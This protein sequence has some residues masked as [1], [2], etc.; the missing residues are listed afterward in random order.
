MSGEKTE[1]AAAA[2]PE[3]KVATKAVGMRTIADQV[4]EVFKSTSSCVEWRERES[5]RFFLQLNTEQTFDKVTPFM[6][7]RVIVADAFKSSRWR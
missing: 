2:P 3:A 4:L 1:A 5:I 6:G 7:L